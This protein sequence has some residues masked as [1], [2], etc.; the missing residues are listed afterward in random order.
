M[1]QVLTGPGPCQR[2]RP[3]AALTPSKAPGT[4]HFYPFRGLALQIKGDMKNGFRLGDWQVYP[5]RNLLVGPA[6]QVHIEPKVIQVLEQLAGNPGKAV[7][8]KDNGL[9]GDSVRN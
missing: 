8:Q 4:W 6:R 9:A 7:S 1:I 3:F 5:L 2:A